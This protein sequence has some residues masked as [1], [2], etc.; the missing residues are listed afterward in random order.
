M[1]V[2]AAASGLLTLEVWDLEQDVDKS[3]TQFD[4]H[5]MHGAGR[6]GR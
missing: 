5:F 6:K 3:H 4:T 1:R 2:W